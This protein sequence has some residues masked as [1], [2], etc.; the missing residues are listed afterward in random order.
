M[1][2]APVALFT[3]EHDREAVLGN[4]VCEGSVLHIYR[5]RDAAAAPR[6]HRCEGQ[7]LL[8][9]AALQRRARALVPG[10]FWFRAGVLFNSPGNCEMTTFILGASPQLQ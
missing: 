2:V 6:R 10:G 1:A 5:V 7:A 9:Q 3:A 8:R 4:Y